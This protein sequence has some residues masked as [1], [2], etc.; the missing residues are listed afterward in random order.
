MVWQKV[1]GHINNNRIRVESKDLNRYP[2]ET[3]YKADNEMVYTHMVNSANDWT[4][5]A[6]VDFDG[7]KP[8]TDHVLTGNPSGGPPKQ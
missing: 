5:W 4:L 1:V 8:T 2:V 6:D 7:D 3:E